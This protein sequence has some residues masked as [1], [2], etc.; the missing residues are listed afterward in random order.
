MSRRYPPT[1]F[2]VSLFATPSPAHQD[3]FYTV[4]RAG[5]LLGGPDNHIQRTHFPGH[6]LILCCGG[7]GWVR[8]DGRTHPVKSGDFVWINCHRPHEHAAVKDDPWEV[9]WI[10]VEGPRLEQ[11]CQILAVAT[12]P[13]FGGFDRRSAGVL[14]RQ[15]FKQMAGEG[16]NAPAL[17]HA[18]VARLIAL[19]FCARQ[20]TPGPPV[21][22]PRVLARPVER[23]RL[24]YFE[25]HTVAG[26]A[27][28]AGMSTTHFARV[29]K[30]TFGTSPIDWLRRERISQ[31]KRRLVETTA[32]IKEIA[33]QVGY[34]DRYFFSKDFK[35]HTGL[36]PRQFRQREGGD[37][38]RPE[39]G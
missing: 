7:R 31:A 24:F 13:V 19:A 9:L 27:K 6:E 28:L 22:V 33:E 21:V 11:I 34:A 14:Y 18:L 39:P 20:R 35:Q 37:W 15:I 17:V 30:A 32:A 2:P 12:T 4:P 36:T 5:H 3:I 16:P 10:R 38:R 26:L 8:I 29:F 1:R 25:R 23:I